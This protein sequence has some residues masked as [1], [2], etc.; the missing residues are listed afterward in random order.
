MNFNKNKLFSSFFCALLLLT[1][2]A[3]LKKKTVNSETGIELLSSHAVK[4]ID[5]HIHKILDSYEYINIG[6]V[7]NNQIVLAKSYGNQGIDYVACYCSC[8]KPVTAM[9]V[10]ML[11]SN[12]SIKSIDDNIWKY[13]SRYNNCLPPQYSSS[14]LTF[15]HLL[16]HTSGIPHVPEPA[17]KNNKLNLIFKPGSMRTYS[18]PA[19]GIIGEVLEDI[20]G[21]PFETILKEYISQ[22]INA[23]SLQTYSH[24]HKSRFKIKYNTRNSKV[25]F[26]T[27]AGFIFS[28]I[29]DMALF[30][31]GV[32]NGT[33]VS[34]DL[35]YNSILIPDK[36]NDEFGLGWKC[37]I[38]DQDIIG[39]HDGAMAESRAYIMIRPKMK[40]SVVILARI[41]SS[42]KNNYLEDLSKFLMSS[43]MQTSALD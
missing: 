12:G 33:Y 8:G 22:P 41:K 13:S 7:H 37:S 30:T 32:M 10:M 1:V 2:P 18:T 27:P 38:N 31:I 17:W 23:T 34:E 29:T 24:Y 35:L 19:Y 4:N 36:T 9:I 40:L 11:V 43:M 14:S 42:V 21:K 6:L 25:L 3:C 28:N 26:L 15:R 39:F 5:K 16:T 20:T